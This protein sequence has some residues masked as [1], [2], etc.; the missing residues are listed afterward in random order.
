LWQLC[1]DLWI[2]RTR[3]E[4]GLTVIYQLF[5]N[6]G[7]SMIRRFLLL[8]FLSCQGFVFAAHAADVPAASVYAKPKP[9]KAKPPIKTR[10]SRKIETKPV[11][12]ILK[13]RSV[14]PAKDDK[15]VSMTPDVQIPSV[16][17]EIDLSWVL[18]PL[19]ANA[20]GKKKEGSASVEGN[21]V[22]LDPGTVSSPYMVIELEGH[23]VKTAETTARIDIKVA[24]KNHTVTWPLDDVKSGTFK[25]TLDSSMQEGKLPATIPVSA[26]AIVTNASKKGGAAMV[27]LERIKIRVGKVSLSDAQ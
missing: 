22:V 21:L 26:I 1:T 9:T 11:P 20:D 13:T 25:V 5:T 3:I 4:R 16:G 18:D 17:K 24:G 12:Q 7:L 2:S 6:W 27:S 15:Q 10:I 19:S 23:I 14:A 8:T